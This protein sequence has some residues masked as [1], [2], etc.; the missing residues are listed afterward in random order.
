MN[1]L[2]LPPEQKT[3]TTTYGAFKGVNFSGTALT[4][5]RDRAPY[6]ENMIGDGAG[7]PEKRSGFKRVCA[8]PGRINGIHGCNI[9]EDRHILVHSGNE[10]YRVSLEGAFQ[11]ILL[12][13][14]VNDTKSSCVSY[15]Y[16]ERII[17]I[18]MTGEKWLAYDGVRIVDVDEYV[19]VPLIIERAHSA[20][21]ITNTYPGNALSRKVKEGF[22]TEGGAINLYVSGRVDMS[23]PYYMEA[24]NYNSALRTSSIDII[25]TT[26]YSYNPSTGYISLDYD[27][28]L[29]PYGYDCNVFFTY[30]DADQ[31]ES[32]LQRCTIA[33]FY[34]PDGENRLYIAGNPEQPACDWVSNVN[35]ALFFAEDSKTVF[36]DQN[37][38]IMGYQKI[39]ADQLIIKEDTGKEVSLYKR[40]YRELTDEVVYEITAGMSGAGAVSTDCF[41]SLQDEPMFLSRTGVLAVTTDTVN[42]E[43]TLQNRSYHIDGKLLTEQDLSSACAVSYKSFY[44]LGVGGNIY[45]LD[46]RHR[47]DAAFEN[48]QF[49]YDGY[50]WT[51]VAARRFV[52]EL[53]TLYVGTEDGRVLR[54]VTDETDPE[55]FMDDGV[56]I[57]AFWETRIDDDDLPTRFKTMQKKG[58]MIVLKDFPKTSA[59]ISVAVD[60]GEFEVVDEVFFARLDFDEFDFN[61]LSFSTAVDPG[62]YFFNKKV[63]R[64]NN[65]QFRIENSQP[66]EGFG[67]YQLT[68]TYTDEGFAK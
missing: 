51:G 47:T 30:F 12:A 45:L 3:Y 40:S 37:Y 22:F 21:L 9:G 50:F 46:N 19:T 4:V 11:P 59:I 62:R 58:G 38:R 54:Y 68:K 36:G 43:R 18:I 10:I 5:D 25:P 49:V 14:N 27:V 53:G 8:L 16:G 41:A 15:M 13:E 44:M 42:S 52:V 57:R 65:M 28:R 56:S 29:T 26:A 34:G 6:A 48:S 17:A 1:I 39:G 35:D 66:D 24:S 64:Y 55:R 67:V 2:T 31:P 33:T 20:N 23:K 63:K 32:P 7:M 60:G 61:S